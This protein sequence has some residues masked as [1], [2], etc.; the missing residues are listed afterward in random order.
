MPRRSRTP[1]VINLVPGVV[2]TIEGDAA[3][4]ISAVYRV[5]I[6]EDDVALSSTIRYNLQ[7]QGYHVT[8]AHGG[9]E[10]LKTARTLRPDLVVLDLM[11]P[12]IDGRQV[13]RHLRTWTQIPILILTAMDREEDIVAGLDAGADDYLTKPFGMAEL[14]ARV[15][16]LLRRV[17]T[18]M[19]KPDTLVAGDLVILLNEYRATYAGRELRLPRKEFQLLTILAR[20]AGRAFSRADLLDRVWGDDVVVDPRNIDVHIRWIRVQ[21]EGNPDGSW[22]IQTVHGVG[23][24]FA[25]E[26][27]PNVQAPER[28]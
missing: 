17:G 27:G 15:R 2:T 12:E 18:V 14:M 20:N 5:L 24:R 7:K 23:Y 4:T 19:D 1:K 21:L 26:L 11:L 25:G 28:E 6:V 22:L 16:S 13:C 10:G 9:A 3:R 8:V